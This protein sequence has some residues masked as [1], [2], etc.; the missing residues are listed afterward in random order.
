M[1]IIVLIIIIII[2]AVVKIHVQ[3]Y[4]GLEVGGAWDMHKGGGYRGDE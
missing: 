2:I 1:T 4:I 3:H